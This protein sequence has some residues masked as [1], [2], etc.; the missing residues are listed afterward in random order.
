M[1]RYKR[2][3]LNRGG[4]VL[5]TCQRDKKIKAGNLNLHH[6]VNCVT[7]LNLTFK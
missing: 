3:Q 2:H 1:M 4:F 6:A 5:D 7:N